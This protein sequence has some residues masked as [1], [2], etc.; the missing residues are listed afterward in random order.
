MKVTLDQGVELVNSR[1]ELAIESL[2]E[3]G[4]WVERCTGRS[5]EGLRDS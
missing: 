5:R 1:Q 3:P 2:E 4:I